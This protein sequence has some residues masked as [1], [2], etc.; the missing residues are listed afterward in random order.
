MTPLAQQWLDALA[1][2][3]VRA[4]LEAVYDYIAACVEA[5]AP[6]CTASGRCCN[7]DAFDHRLY[8]TGL[9]TA[10]TMLH[11]DG[12]PVSSEAL[13]EAIGRGGCP[14]QP[15]RLCEA[16]AARPAGCRVYFCDPT[17]QAWQEGL[18]ERVCQAI[19][20]IHTRHGIEYRYGEWRAML[21]EFVDGHVAGEP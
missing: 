8:V 12:G 18:G 2:A 21:R 16:R 13:D 20:D 5:R 1:D 10:Y 14:Y 9:E 17:A 11:P 6:I 15:A 7:F 3:G 19:R 4:E